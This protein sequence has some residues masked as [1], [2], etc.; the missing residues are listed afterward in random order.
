M[1]PCPGSELEAGNGLMLLI[2]PFACGIS[3]YSLIQLTT[4]PF[5][6]WASR[7]SVYVVCQSSYYVS[8]AE[9][10]EHQFQC[11]IKSATGFPLYL[12]NTSSN[13]YDDM[14]LPRCWIL[15]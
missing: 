6:L 4:F 9:R 12:R 1:I 14:Y 15:P 8:N 11:D 7:N 3:R 5:R 10:Q 2:Q 13:T